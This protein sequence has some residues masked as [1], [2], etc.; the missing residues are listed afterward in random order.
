MLVKVRTVTA[1]VHLPAKEMVRT[2]RRVARVSMLYFRSPSTSGK[3]LVIAMTV[4]K[5]VTKQVTNLQTPA[6]E[7]EAT[8]YAYKLVFLALDI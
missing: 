2:P 8:I 6:K 3:S 7:C 5:T 4:A 1:T